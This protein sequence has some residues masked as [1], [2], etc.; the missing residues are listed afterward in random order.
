MKILITSQGPYFTG[1]YKKECTYNYMSPAVAASF[2]CP[3]NIGFFN[4]KLRWVDDA[5]Q[6]TDCDLAILKFLFILSSEINV[7]K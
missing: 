2:F 6:T 7:A 4:F 1:P 3:Q 5:N